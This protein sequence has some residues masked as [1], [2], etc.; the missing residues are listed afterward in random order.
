MHLRFSSSDLH[1]GIYISVGEM[2]VSNYLSPSKRFEL[3]LTNK[4]SHITQWMLP[5]RK[6]PLSKVAY[7]RRPKFH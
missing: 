2:I 6:K 1:A 7:Y 4:V 3:S 5:T